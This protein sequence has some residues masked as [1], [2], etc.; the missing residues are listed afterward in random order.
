[1]YIRPP[2]DCGGIGGGGLFSYFKCVDEVELEYLG[3][4]GFWSP[5]STSPDVRLGYNLIPR[6]GE[7]KGEGAHTGSGSANLRGDEVSKIDMA[8]VMIS[9]GGGNLRGVMVTAIA[10][11]WHGRWKC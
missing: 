11:D 1:M 9:L 4:P 2:P 10:I 3:A 8:V 5:W 7:Y 6:R